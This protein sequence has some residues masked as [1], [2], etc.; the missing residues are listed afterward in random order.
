QKTV[1][2][3]LVVRTLVMLMI[4]L[5]TT[6]LRRQF[7]R[8]L[9]QFPELFAGKLESSMYLMKNSGKS[10]TLI[11]FEMQQ[12]KGNIE[13]SIIEPIREEDLI[14][15]SELRRM[16][17]WLKGKKQLQ[18]LLEK[19]DEEQLPKEQAQLLTHLAKKRFSVQWK[20]K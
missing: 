18:R 1:N 8:Y 17:S 14:Q 12:H 5:R 16:V 13:V 6:A 11:L 2:E 19:E 3:T 15:D 10:M 7:A 4:Y 20:L 9:L